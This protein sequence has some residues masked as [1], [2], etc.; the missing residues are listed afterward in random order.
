VY[1]EAFSQAAESLGEAPLVIPIVMTRFVPVLATATNRLF[2]Y[3]TA[4]HEFASGALRAVQV[5][6]SGLVMTRF[7]PEM[8]TATNRLF[9]YVTAHHMSSDTLRAVQVVPSGLVMTRLVPE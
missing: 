2:P 1:E 8:A 3:V 6:P 9:P 4:A 7:V 5:V